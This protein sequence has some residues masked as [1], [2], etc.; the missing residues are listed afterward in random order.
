MKLLI[1]TSAWIEYFTGSKEGEIVNKYL[2][3]NEI[4]TSVVSLLE[5]SYKADKE[6]WNIRDYLNFI[7]I[8]S[9]I[10]GIKESSIIEFGKLYNF[11]RKKEG[12]FGFAD[13]IILM[14]SKSEEAKILT[15]DNHFKNFDNIIML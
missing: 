9:Q 14:T 13:A 12:S 1:D 5:L 3:E 2:N 4:L 10:Y 7:K 8:K 11:S 15:K 6:G